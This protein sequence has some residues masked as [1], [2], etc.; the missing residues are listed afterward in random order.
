MLVLWTGNIVYENPLVYKGMYA[1]NTVG[2]M[3]IKPQS[4]GAIF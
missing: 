4:T 2:K 1:K 3:W